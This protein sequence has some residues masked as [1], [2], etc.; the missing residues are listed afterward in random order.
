MK[1]LNPLAPALQGSKW[2]LPT[3]GVAV[4]FP[5]SNINKFKSSIEAGRGSP[6]PSQGFQGRLG[7]LGHALFPGR[8]RNRR[9]CQCFSRKLNSKLNRKINTK[10]GRKA[11]NGAD[12]EVDSRADRG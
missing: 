9:C 1:T 10:I 8:L 6:G 4:L 3:T 12:K 2:R 5:I 11:G 7:S